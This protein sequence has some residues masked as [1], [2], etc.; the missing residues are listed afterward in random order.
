MIVARTRWRLTL[1]N[2]AALMVLVLLLGAAIV[3]AMN[4][5]LLAQ[6]TSN[7]N[8]EA[9][10]GAV[11]FEELSASEFQAKHPNFSTGTFYLVWNLA[12]IPV[13]NP[14]NID[15]RPLAPAAL[16]ALHKR[17]G[18]QTVSFS[19]SDDVL[20]ASQLLVEDNNPLGALQV[21]HSLAPLHKV[22]S[23]AIVIV[24]LACVAM[25]GVSV[26]AGW[27]LAGRALVPIRETLDRQ[28]SFTADASHEL[29]S[30]LTVIDTGIQVLRRHPEQLIEE[31]SDVLSSMQ[32]ESQRMGRL[33]A[34]LLALARADSGDAELQLAD[35][36]VADLVRAAVKDVEPLASAKDCV[37]KTAHVEAGLVQLD[38]DRF[39]QLIVI[40]VDNAVTHGPRGSKIEVSCRRHDRTLTLEVSDHGPGIPADQRDKVFER[41]HR[42]SPSRNGSGAGLGLSIAKWI[43]T[44]HGGS[45][46]LHDNRP[47]LRLEVSLPLSQV[48]Q[49]GR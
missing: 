6:E 1:I 14:T 40:L 32:Q 21:G 36:E 41:F 33:V 4:G 37:V 9:R 11:D 34:S 30:P 16:A 29:R 26:L 39:K 48:G 23:E 19:G 18:T 17:S 43:V 3:V 24:A 22:Q 42:L 13:F 20:V 44:A 38:A 15:T 8:A 2:A 10:Q 49:T 27:F 12:G 45:I 47:G 5:F 35:V 7:L 46:T 31:Y 25:L 28:K